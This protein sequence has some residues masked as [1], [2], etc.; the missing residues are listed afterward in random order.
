MIVYLM[1]V[2]LALSFTSTLPSAL[3]KTPEYAI[4]KCCGV[5]YTECCMDSLRFTRPLHCDGMTLRAKIDVI[6]CIQSELHGASQLSV[7][8]FTDTTCCEV[9]ADNDN[10]LNSECENV[11]VSVMQMAGLRN[12]QKLMKIKMCLRRNP[13]HRVSQLVSCNMFKF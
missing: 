6:D 3:A 2:V 5:K 10:D 8:N 7:L 9:F 1:A 13:L 4:E 11:C 12:D